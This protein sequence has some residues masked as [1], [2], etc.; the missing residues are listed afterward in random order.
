MLVVGFHK[1]HLS[2]V[3]LTGQIV[4]AY[5]NVVQI[6]DCSIGNCVL[7]AL[8]AGICPPPCDGTV[9]GVGPASSFGRDDVLFAIAV[10]KEAELMGA[11]HPF[12]IHIIIIY[13]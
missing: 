3:N 5:P 12:F 2:S 10:V 8:F 1:G 7:Q 4:V 13:P 11:G 6:Q 9:G